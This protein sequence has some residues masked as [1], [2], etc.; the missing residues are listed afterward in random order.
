MANCGRK[1][2]QIVNN[3][4]EN[5][6]QCA[7]ETFHTITPPAAD[8]TQHRLYAN[9]QAYKVIISFSSPVVALPPFVSV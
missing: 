1:W 4:T 3:N 6:I 5:N 7:M 8:F 2:T 9:L